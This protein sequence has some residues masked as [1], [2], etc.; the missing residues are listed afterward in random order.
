MDR[1]ALVAIATVAVGKALDSLNLNGMG[2][3]G[4]GVLLGERGV[5]T[6]DLMT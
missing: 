6:D 4:G 3:W 5:M 2:Q 1:A